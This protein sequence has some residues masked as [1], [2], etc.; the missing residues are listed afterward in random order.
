MS[1]EKKFQTLIAAL[2]DANRLANELGL[3]CQEE[4][5]DIQDR[6]NA[7]AIEEQDDL[8]KFVRSKDSQ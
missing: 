8:V 2:S 1:R 4:L 5:S 7:Q 3:D 6:I